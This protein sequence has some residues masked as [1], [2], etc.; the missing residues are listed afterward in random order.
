[1]LARAY[2]KAHAINTA[3]AL[4]TAR[5]AT[6]AAAARGGRSAAAA[7][8]AAATA[9]ALA[10]ARDERVHVLALA[11]LG[12]EGGPVGL[13]LDLGLGEEGVDVVGRDVEALVVK[14]QGSIHARKLG[15]HGSL[16]SPAEQTRRAQTR[17]RGGERERACG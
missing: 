11:K 8:A 9:A 1:M 4:N 12:E 2:A 14:D 3:A 17:K 5:A 15:A 16:S 6:A 7:A 10:H 13:D